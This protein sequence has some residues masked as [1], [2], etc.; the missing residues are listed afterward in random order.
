M[1]HPPSMLITTITSN[2]K[3]EK[4]VIDY[5]QLYIL[6]DSLSDTGSFVGAGS[7]FVQKSPLAPWW[8]AQ[9][10]LGDPY[11]LNRSFSN[12][13]VAAEILANK[14]HL[15]LQAG[16]KYT[17]L[18]DAATYEQFGNNYA[19]G[20]AVAAENDSW[21]GTFYS[22]RFSLQHQMAAF[23][24]QHQDLQSD[25]L[26]FLE[27][28]NNDMLAAIDSGNYY[29]GLDIIYNAII[30]E[31][32]II[33]ELINK[34]I[35]HIVATD[36]PDFSLVPKYYGTKSQVLAKQL[37]DAYKTLWNHEISLY[38]TNYP[39]FIRRFSLREALSKYALIFQQEGKNITQNA[40][41]SDYA[42]MAL[43]GAV[44]ATYVNGSTKETL[45]N[46][47]FFDEVHPTTLVHQA[48]AEDLYN[49]VEKW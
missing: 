2:I 5:H 49:L 24:S 12:G 4:T 34:G 42:H 18:N 43:D 28:G 16:W 36:V 27:S 20:G 38:I 13:K 46:Y 35:Q 26:V 15:N 47:F 40:I 45:N 31:G 41:E 8:V 33:Q 30:K 21:T 9:V 3:E 32:D 29:K 6:G 10:E 14:L 1:A 23:L 17:I 7:D 22:N 37:S 44:T 19:V 11:Y 25:D 48:V 39:N